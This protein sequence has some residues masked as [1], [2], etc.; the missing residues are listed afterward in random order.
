[1]ENQNQQPNEQQKK[2]YE[3]SK[4]VFF[5]L[6]IEEKLFGSRPGGEDGVI[7]KCGAIEKW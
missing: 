7:A 6:K 1:M 5:P 4:A 2:P 3:S